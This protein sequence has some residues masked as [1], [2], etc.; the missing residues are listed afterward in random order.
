M[1]FPSPATD[2]IE[3]RISITSLCSLGANTRVVETSDGYAV[4]DVSRRPVQGDT[5]LIRY[6]GR[7]EFAK[8]MG[9][10]L[11]T[12]DGEA[13]E[14]E[15]LDDVTVIGVVTFTICDVRQDNAVV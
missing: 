1:G 13:I 2:Y 15:A 5:V 6:D 8:L 11:I 3:R 4:I 9:G 7:M 10:A 12:A 14:G